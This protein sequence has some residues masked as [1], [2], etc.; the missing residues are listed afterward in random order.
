MFSKGRV[1]PEVLAI[2]RSVDALVMVLLGG[3]NTLVGPIVGAAAFTWLQD[4]LARNTEY[5]RAALGLTIL[6]LVVLF[7]RGIV[8]TIG[9][10]IEALVKRRRA[11]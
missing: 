6:G 7:Q 9:P 8:G 2:P 4:T 10:R 5:W 1:S 11:P 3:M